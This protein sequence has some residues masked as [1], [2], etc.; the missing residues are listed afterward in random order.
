MSEFLI[1]VFFMFMCFLQGGTVPV[2]GLDFLKCFISFAGMFIF[3]GFIFLSSFLLSSQS[4]FKQVQLNSQGSTN[5]QLILCIF[6]DFTFSELK[7]IPSICLVCCHSGF[8][9]FSLHIHATVVPGCK[10]KTGKRFQSF[11]LR[12]WK[13]TLQSPASQ[14]THSVHFSGRH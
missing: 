7:P 5:Q 2:M 1:F 3:Y 10:L 14:R 4:L 8:F 11:H 9:A 13:Y 6:K 12:M